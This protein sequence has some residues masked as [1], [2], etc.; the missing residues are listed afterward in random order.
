[1]NRHTVFDL[2]LVLT[3]IATVRYFRQRERTV[4][5]S[6]T[7]SQQWAATGSADTT[8][9]A[10]ESTE[11]STLTRIAT[12]LNTRPEDAAE[13]VEQLDE[14]VRTLQSDAERTRMTWASRWWE[15]RSAGALETDKR[16]ITVVSLP[17]GTVDDATALAK[18]HDDPLGIAIITAHTDGTLAVAV[19]TGI[20]DQ[21]ADEIARDVATQAG[22]GAGGDRS[23]ATGGGDADK[24]TDAATA[25]RDRLSSDGFVT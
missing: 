15:A 1:M 14:K 17:D 19:G 6:L 12:L 8:P 11:P 16:H 24:L 3:L 21:R 13:R 18:A 7:L 4:R 23:L 10:V 5:E 9:A 2:A 22:G 20:D 25:V